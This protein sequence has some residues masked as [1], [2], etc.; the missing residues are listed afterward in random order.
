MN[1]TTMTWEFMALIFVFLA[2]LIGFIIWKNRKDRKKF[3]RDMNRDYR[4]SKNEEGENDV[5]DT[6]T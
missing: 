2:G 3:E 1:V 5:T 4:R 6:R